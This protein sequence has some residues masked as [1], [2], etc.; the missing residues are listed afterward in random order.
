MALG[1][2]RE[3][4]IQDAQARAGAVEEETKE[5]TDRII[6][7]AR[8]QARDILKKAREEAQKWV[9]TFKME[10]DAEV[11]IDKHNTVLLAKEEAID[12][13]ER[14]VLRAVTAEINRKYPEIV[15]KAV[16]QMS[17]LAMVGE[18]QLVIVAEEKYQRMLKGTKMSMETG[19]TGIRIESR[20]KRIATDIS[21]EVLIADAIG[22]IKSL[23]SDALFEEEAK[24]AGK[25]KSEKR[26]AAERREEKGEKWKG[27]RR[28]KEKKKEEKKKRERKR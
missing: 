22:D 13:N 2:M 28:K 27:E 26:K 23:I 11:Q 8:E 4:I 18:N 15:Q 12:A 24:A 1:K 25:P 16:A 3:D 14:E 19:H 7:Q 20:D 17:R 6:A 21:P 10:H 5:E 9:E